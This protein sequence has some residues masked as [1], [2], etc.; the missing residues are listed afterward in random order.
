[1]FGGVF[2]W[3]KD[4]YVLPS[5]LRTYIE[6]PRQ[7]IELAAPQP[8][9]VSGVPVFCDTVKFVLAISHNHHGS[10]P[11][12]VDR[13]AFRVEPL[14][15]M[16]DRLVGKCEI[17]HL[18][19]RPYGIEPRNT[20]VIS[21]AKG[22]PKVTFIKSDKPGQ[23]ELAKTDNI[24]DT[25]AIHVSVSLRSDDGPTSYDVYVTL[26]NGQPSRI[27]FDVYY[28]SGSPKSASTNSLVLAP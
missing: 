5:D 3:F 26:R 4:T 2:V 14:N 15:S 22:L 18:A 13:I 8:S 12:R 6:H 19:Q 20:Y 16:D 25:K 9:S 10:T 27:W 24:L 28:D 11:I 21:L 23:A 17:N 7:F 1:M